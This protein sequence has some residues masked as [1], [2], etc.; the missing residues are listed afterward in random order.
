[1]ATIHGIKMD[2]YDKAVEL[3]TLA[4]DHYNDSLPSE[5]FSLSMLYYFRGGCYLQLAKFDNVIDDVTKA[6]SFNDTVGDNLSMVY[7]IRGIAYAQLGNND[8]AI[9]DFSTGLGIKDHWMEDP[10]V[11]KTFTTYLTLLSQ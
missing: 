10:E 5:E 8:L 2:H 9:Q 7:V 4:I 6:L 1:M 3:F 11:F